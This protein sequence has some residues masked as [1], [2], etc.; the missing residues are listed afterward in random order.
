MPHK[1]LL[2]QGHY[3]EGPFEDYHIPG[4]TTEKT[5][6]AIWNGHEFEVWSPE[7][8]GIKHDQQRWRLDRY[9]HE[10]RSLLFHP[11]DPRITVKDVRGATIAYPNSLGTHW[12]FAHC[13]EDF[14]KDKELELLAIVDSAFQSVLESRINDCFAVIGRDIISNAIAKYN[15][16]KIFRDKVKTQLRTDF[17]TKYLGWFHQNPVH[18][19]VTEMIVN[20]MNTVFAEYRSAQK[21]SVIY[22]D[23]QNALAYVTNN[24]TYETRWGQVARIEAEKKKESSNEEET[25]TSQS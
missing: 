10:Y 13:D 2:K 22:T 5:Y 14:H 25:E 8:N 7:Y 16:V 4:S 3:F 18:S 12:L 19:H 21:H 20:A 23:Y 9:P 15:N 1:S 17:R 24:H 6:L 11:I